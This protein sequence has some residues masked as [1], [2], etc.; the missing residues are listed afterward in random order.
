MKETVR[1]KI[2][3]LLEAGDTTAL[4]I[5]GAVRI[6]EREVYDHLAH[7]DRSLKARGRRVEI[8]PS[9]CLGC[10]YVFSD[11]RRFTRPGRCPRCRGIRIA[12]PVYRIR[13]SG[14]TGTTEGVL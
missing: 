13:L 10:G 1:R 6:R 2:I 9:E 3:R 14:D 7:I 4:D 5:S 12:Y 11:R 8:V